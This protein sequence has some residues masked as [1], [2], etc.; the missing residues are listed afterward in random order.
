MQRFVF[1]HH[2]KRYFIIALLVLLSSTAYCKP[3]SFTVV[4]KNFPVSIKR[5]DQL[6]L[7]QFYGEEFPVLDSIEIRTD[8]LIRFTLPDFHDGLYALKFKS[9]KQNQA[10]LILSKSDTAILVTANYQDIMNGEAIIENSM[11][12]E[13]YARLIAVRQHYQPL[14]DEQASAL[15]TVSFFLPDYKRQLKLVEDRMEYLYQSFDASLQEVRN[16]FPRTYT[17]G[18]LVP[19]ALIPYRN[20]HDIWP[21][22]YDGYRALLHDHFF[23]SIN[24]NDTRLLR[25]YAYIDKVHE[26]LANYTDKTSDGSRA[27]IDVIMNS[28]AQ[29]EEVNSFVYT[30]LLKVFLKYKSEV[31]VNYITEKHPNGCALNLSMEELTRLNNM[32]SSMVGSKGR[33]ILLYDVNGKAQSLY[34]QCKKNKATVLIYWISWCARCK[35]E[36]PEIQAIYERYRKQGLG[37]FAVSVDEKK[38]EWEKA[39]ALNGLSGI[40]VSELVP[41]K[42]SKVLALYNVTTTPAIFLLDREGKILAKG[43][44]GSDLED[45]VKAALK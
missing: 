38:E 28:L 23:D 39:L 31:L 6:Q 15:E 40:N 2:M 44:L 36:T 7:L 13:A 41:L 4:I 22:Q 19:M 20:Q 32:Q 8:T 5:I 43:L 45:A 21:L 26:Y 9:E 34:E 24:T 25:H 30:S 42:E 14:F 11:E 27:G 37:L 10:E 12:N 33:D 35:K 16:A 17:A 29:N 3:Y 18:V 1:I